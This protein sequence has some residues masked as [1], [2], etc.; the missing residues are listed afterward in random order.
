MDSGE[1][2]LDWC[3]QPVR[4]ICDARVT[5]DDWR[6]VREMLG[7]LEGF[8]AERHDVSRER[9]TTALEVFRAAVSPSPR[10]HP[11]P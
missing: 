2:E 1:V 7:Y 11:Q 6:D 9:L 10:L 5:Q 8:L 4:E 3:T